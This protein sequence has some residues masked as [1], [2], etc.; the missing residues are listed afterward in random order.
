[1]PQI[2]PAKID[3]YAAEHTT[4]LPPLLEELV[5]ETESKFPD[6]FEM[7]C[8]QVEG[9]F[10]R[11]LVAASRA[12]RVLEIGTFT[13]FSALCMASGLPS[14][15]ELITL[16]LDP[17][18]AAF[19]RSYFDRSGDKSKITLIEGPALE[20][21]KSMT[22]AFDFAFIDA[23]KVNYPNYYE[24]TVPLMSAG[25]LIAVDN[26]LR[27]GKVLKPK[28]EPSKATAQLNDIITEDD[29]VENVM[30]TVRDGIMLARKK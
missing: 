2:V 24:A 3:K 6:R 25:G 29:R 14:D 5:R 21:L 7:L 30:L 9:Q 20:S 1:V 19:A 17:E 13:G 11:A 15:G 22:G 26:A 4:P 18:H 10:L 27:E 28:G 12:K 16:E 8:G 23:D